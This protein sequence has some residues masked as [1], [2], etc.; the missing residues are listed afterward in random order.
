MNIKAN[1]IMGSIITILSFWML[2]AILATFVTILCLLGWIIVYYKK[3]QI[4][5]SSSTEENGVKEIL[6]EMD[7][8]SKEYVEAERCVKSNRQLEATTQGFR[9]K[10]PLSALFNRE[11]YIDKE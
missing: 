7:E 4:T 1:M 8:A 3:H 9:A 11:N 10:S 2:S 5:H 6:S